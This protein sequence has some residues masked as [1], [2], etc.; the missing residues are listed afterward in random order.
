[1]CFGSCWSLFICS[2]LECTVPGIY[3]SLMKF[4]SFDC[5]FDEAWQLLCMFPVTRTTISDFSKFTV[6]ACK[7]GSWHNEPAMGKLAIAI[8][9]WSAR[10]PAVFCLWQ[11]ER[12]CRLLVKKKH[13]DAVAEANYL[14]V[15]AGT[16]MMNWLRSQSSNLQLDKSSQL[17]N[18]MQV[19]WWVNT[20]LRHLFRFRLWRTP[21]ACC[22]FAA[23]AL[24]VQV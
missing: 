8:M 3:V 19:V 9:H 23:L 1:M 6:L 10:L 4:G 12:H 2:W 11:I 14:A 20:V 18:R 21:V 22:M 16:L 13:S 5:C 15:E 17:L 7:F 24:S